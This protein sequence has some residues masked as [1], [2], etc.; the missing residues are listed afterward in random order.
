MDQ[1]RWCETLADKYLA[2][3]TDSSLRQRCMKSTADVANKMR[4]VMT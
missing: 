2:A 1:V 4:V 3:L